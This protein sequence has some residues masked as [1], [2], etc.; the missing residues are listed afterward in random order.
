MEISKLEKSIM[1]YNKTVDI[2][3]V[4]ILLKDLK[5]LDLNDIVDVLYTEFN[6]I[7]CDII[8]IYHSDREN[9]I[10]LL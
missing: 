7:E 9:K 6:K 5:K 10:E 1:T 8:K 2:P 4:S 3:N